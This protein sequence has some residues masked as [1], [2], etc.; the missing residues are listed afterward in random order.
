[1]PRLHPIAIEDKSPCPGD[2]HGNQTPL[3]RS[4]C[5]AIKIFEI[6]AVLWK[7]VHGGNEPTAANETLENVLI[8]WEP[9]HFD[10]SG[11]N[12]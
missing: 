8:A 12:L 6:G 2:E 4:R 1:M 11:F 7:K 10:R 3:N 5:V 9:R